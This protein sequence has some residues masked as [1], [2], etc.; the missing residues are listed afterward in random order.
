MLTVA[1]VR[2]VHTNIVARDWKALALFYVKAFGCRRKPPERNLRGAWLDKAT[3]LEG[4]HIKGIHLV[5]PGFGIDGPTLEIFQ[6]SRQQRGKLP[7]INKPGFAHIAFSVVNV[8]KALE[9]VRQCG[10]GRVG[11]AVSAE[12]E[13]VGH[14]SFAYARDPEGNIIELQKWG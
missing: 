9:K 11:R 8:A 3:S 5:L 13:G 4:A 10:G 14:V 2:Y 12:V 7:A 1:A 6:Y